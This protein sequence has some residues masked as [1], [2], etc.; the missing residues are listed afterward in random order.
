MGALVNIGEVTPEPSPPESED[1]GF[2][3]ANVELVRDLESEDFLDLLDRV[4]DADIQTAFGPGLENVASAY[5]VQAGAG[6]RSLAV[7]RAIEAPT[8]L[9]DGWGKLRVHVRDL[10]PAPNLSVADVRFYEPDQK[11]IRGDVVRDVNERLQDDV[12]VLLMLGLARP[13]QMPWDDRQRHWLQCNGLV[14]KDR[15]VGPAP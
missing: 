5:A 10:D 9:V 4:R 2:Q 1:H 13:M 15:P 11:T 12:G 8:L 6:E 14:L 7:V 3:T